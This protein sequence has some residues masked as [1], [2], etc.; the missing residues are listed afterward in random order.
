MLRERDKNATATLA[1]DG[2]K[3]F[4]ILLPDSGLPSTATVAEGVAPIVA[5]EPRSNSPIRR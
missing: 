3:E 4:A 5:G 1:S 2:G